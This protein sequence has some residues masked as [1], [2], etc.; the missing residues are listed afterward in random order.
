MTD[1]EYLLGAENI[2]KKL[3]LEIIDKEKEISRWTTYIRV[4]KGLI[5]NESLS[6]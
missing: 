4:L 6:R 3:R 5:S 2:I 1:N